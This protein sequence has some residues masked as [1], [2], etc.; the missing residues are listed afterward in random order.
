MPQVITD[1]RDI[2]SVLY[3]QFN[4]EELTQ[5]AKFAEF[6]K[7]TF[8]LIIREA[9]KLAVKE[10]LPTFAEMHSITPGNASRAKIRCWGRTKVEHRQLRHE[11]KNKT[12]FRS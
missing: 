1:R 7:K 4:V 9:R 2:D 6:N 3:E 11:L 5:H 8:D 12:D 10:I